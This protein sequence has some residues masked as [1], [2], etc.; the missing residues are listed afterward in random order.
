MLLMARDRFLTLRELDASERAG[1]GVFEA[2]VGRSTPPSR[3]DSDSVGDF[4]IDLKG[5][6]GSVEF[7]DSGDELGDGSVM[8]GESKVEIVVVGDESVESEEIEAALL[9]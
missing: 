6:R 1:S 2:T 3:A 9:C 7:G 5:D 8:D 4:I